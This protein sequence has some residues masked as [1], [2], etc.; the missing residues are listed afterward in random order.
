MAE[1]RIIA[2]GDVHGC[3]HALD[4]LLDVI[5][6]EADDTLVFLGDLVDQGPETREV[7][8]R[9]IELKLRCCVVLIE[10]NHEEMMFAAREARVRCDIGNVAAER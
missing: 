9:V 8:E 6:P 7:L 1:G 3:A 2:V 10:G 4:A 5:L